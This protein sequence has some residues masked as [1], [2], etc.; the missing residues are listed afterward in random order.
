MGSCVLQNV[1]AKDKSSFLSFYELY[2]C[3]RVY[4]L[5]KAVFTS[6]IVT[7]VNTVSLNHFLLQQERRMNFPH[8]L[9]PVTSKEWT[10][11]IRVEIITQTARKVRRGCTARFPVPFSIY[12]TRLINT[13]FQTCLINGEEH[14]IIDALFITKTAKNHTLCGHTYLGDPWAPP[15][16]GNKHCIDA[17]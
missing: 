15:P 11:C 17:F 1:L 12:W 2:I 3:T 7:D 10:A 5:R 13:L 6:T 9:S 14:L 4:S 16:P 8:N